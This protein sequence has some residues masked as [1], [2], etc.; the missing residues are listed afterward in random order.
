MPPVIGILE[1]ALYVADLER[2]SAFYRAIFGFPTVLS[3]ARLVALRVSDRQV[4]LLFR[5]GAST[6]PMPI[7]DGIIA[8]H[9]GSGPVHL[10]FA[11]PAG[12]LE[13]WEAWLGEHGVAIESR[14]NWD[15]GSQSLYFRDPDQHALEVAT[16][17]LWG[18]S[19]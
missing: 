17:S 4:L 3:D 11:I 13:S 14:V 19:W 7:G 9:D 10:A 2:A 12:S 6:R 5:Q 8:P 1:T 15:S 18:L 16:P